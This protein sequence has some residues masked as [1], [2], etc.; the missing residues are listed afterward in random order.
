[1]PEIWDDDSGA[2]MWRSSSVDA[3]LASTQKTSVRQLATGVPRN[4]VAEEVL[5]GTRVVFD[6]RLSSL[7]AYSDPPPS[8]VPGTVVTVRTAM[9]TTTHHP[10]MLFVK[11][12]NGR[13]GGFHAEHLKPAPSEKRTAHSNYR[14]VVSS[15]G[16]LGDFLRVASGP[17]LVHKATKDLWSLKVSGGEYVIE[18]LFDETG[19][20]L[21]V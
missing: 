2:S 10:G 6:G 14:Q 21:K 12:D 11:W 1:M 3:H 19:K 4:L 16:D 15:L 7:L 13:F 9:G 8:G 17:D 20:P 5:A 18:R